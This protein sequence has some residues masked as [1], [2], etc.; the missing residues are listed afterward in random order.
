MSLELLKELRATL[1]ARRDALQ[2][3][4]ELR[5]QVRR[6]EAEFAAEQNV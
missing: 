3:V 4:I 1:A 6:L 5:K 2:A